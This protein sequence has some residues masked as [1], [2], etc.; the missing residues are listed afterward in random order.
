MDGSFAGFGDDE[1]AEAFRA[2]LDPLPTWDA[3]ANSANDRNNNIS[4]AT[5]TAVRHGRCVEFS[6]T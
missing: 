4:D 2:A 5:T 3:A 1:T 6:S